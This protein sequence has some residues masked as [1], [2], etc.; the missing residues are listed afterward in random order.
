MVLPEFGVNIG[1]ILASLGIAGF[2]IGMAA[3]DTVAD[4]IS[5]FLFFWRVN[6]KLEI[7]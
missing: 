3:K 7:K 4:F 2:A 1:P 6:T 5:G